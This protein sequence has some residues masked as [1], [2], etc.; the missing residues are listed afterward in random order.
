MYTSTGC[1]LLLL[2][3]CLHQAVTHEKL[4]GLSPATYP[5]PKG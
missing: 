3:H 5:K 1:V 2:Q 4:A